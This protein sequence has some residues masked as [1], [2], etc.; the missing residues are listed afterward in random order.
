[1]I[2]QKMLNALNK[3]I[4]E[5]LF[6]S[7][8]YLQMSA[9]F[10]S[11]NLKG[12][13]HWMQVQSQEETAHAMKLY[14]Y[15]L[16]RGGKVA[17]QVIAEPPSEWPSPLA[18]FQAAYKHEQHITGCFEK[19]MDLAGKEEDNAAAI[20]LQWYVTEQVEEEAN[21]SMVVA[22]LKMIKDAPGGLLMLDHALA[23]RS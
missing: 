17:L 20:F 2:G 21:T 23:G 14:R 13:A 18:A 6:S 10:E 7:Y 16:D 1:M 9:W 19:L 5:E 15:I 3:Q 11:T 4:N 8:L 22:Q 12:F